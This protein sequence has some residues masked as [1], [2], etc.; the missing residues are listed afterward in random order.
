MDRLSHLQPFLLPSPCWPL[1][2]RFHVRQ[3]L[4]VCVYFVLNLF[5]YLKLLFLH[6]LL[7]YLFLLYILLF[8][9]RNNLFLFIGDHLHVAGELKS[10]LIQPWALQIQ[11]HVLGWICSCW[12]GYGQWLENLIQPFKLSITLCSFKHAKQEFICVWGPSTLCP[13]FL[14]GLGTSTDSHHYTARL[15]YIAPSRGHPSG[16]WWPLGFAYLWWPGYFHGCSKV[17]VKIWTSWS[18]W[19]YRIFSVKRGVNHFHRSPQAARGSGRQVVGVLCWEKKTERRDI[20][21]WG[22]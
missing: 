5:L 17:N 11:R 4:C 15:E 2:R 3:F 22:F 19:S 16:T 13:A 12:L 6:F 10:R 7:W 8:L 14:F 21:K 1:G 20:L 9:L 18:D